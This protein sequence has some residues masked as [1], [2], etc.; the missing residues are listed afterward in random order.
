MKSLGSACL[1]FSF[2]LMVSACNQETS[3]GKEKL[4]DSVAGSSERILIRGA[5]VEQSEPE[6][7]AFNF[8]NSGMLW[9]PAG[10]F[11]MALVKLSDVQAVREV[12]VDGFWM[13]EHEV[14][15]TQFALFVEAT[16]YQTSAERALDPVDFPAV[17]LDMLV[18]GSFVFS[19]PT[20]N[21]DFNQKHEGIFVAG[22]NW[23]HPTGPSSTIKGKENYPVVQVS[24]DDAAAYAKWI[25]K[26]LPTEVEWEYAV[27]KG[28]LLRSDRLYGYHFSGSKRKGE[29]ASASNKIGFRCIGDAMK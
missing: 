13:D 24:Y 5:S 20:G 3:V 7:E 11:K 16:G 18:P 1:V 10:S 9:V 15:N 22:A 8:D 25:G 27:Q 4:E 12:Q 29:M 26:R 17:P 14:T 28:S 21:D 23:R 2:A 19:S 6:L